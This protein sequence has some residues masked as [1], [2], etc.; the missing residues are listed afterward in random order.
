MSSGAKTEGVKE[1]TARR[2]SPELALVLA[3]GGARAAYQVGVLAAIAE[4]AP[5]LRFPIITGV[6]AGAINTVY[7]A[8]HPGP[9]SEA[10]RGL[11]EQWEKMTSDKVHRIKGSTAVLSALRLLARM[12]FG[13]LVGPPRAK[14]VLDLQPLRKFLSDRLDFEGIDAN[15]LAGRLRA[16]A[17]SAMCYNTGCSVTFVHGVPEIPTWERAQRVAVRTRLTLEHVMA[18]SSIPILFPAV[19]LEDGFY[20]D[21]SVRQTAPLAPAIHLGARR[22]FVVGLRARRPTHAVPPSVEYPTSGLVLGLL[23][24]SVFL[25]ALDAD[26]ERLERVNR[27]LD[28]LPSG[29]VVPDNQ[30][31]VDLFVL[32]P[33]QDLGAL[34]VESADRLPMRLRRILRGMGGRRRGSS[35]FLSYL[36]FDPPYTNRLY[37]LGRADGLAQWPAIEQFLRRS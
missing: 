12:V 37:D 34:A 15:L 1:A 7:L 17:L 23:L 32:R 29:I 28:V 30:R 26:A 4:R 8:S 9:L 33:S 2:V 27:L 18:S 5:S 20:G 35:D 36:L 21:G 13:K 11:R 16:V 24:H 14:G 22:L 6:S 19:R 31:R 10:V 25:D 3:G